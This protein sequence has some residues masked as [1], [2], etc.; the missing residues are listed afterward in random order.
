VRCERAFG[1][2]ALILMTAVPGPR[3]TGNPSGTGEK[4]LQPYSLD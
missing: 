4:P 3:V 2:S 1:S